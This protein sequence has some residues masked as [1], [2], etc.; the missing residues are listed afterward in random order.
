[1][2]G[3][4]LNPGLVMGRMTAGME[5]MRGTVHQVIVSCSADEF[6]CGSGLCIPLAWQCDG[7]KDICFKPA[8]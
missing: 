1:M 4:F 6:L 3:V 8:D 5:Q 7:E 2:G